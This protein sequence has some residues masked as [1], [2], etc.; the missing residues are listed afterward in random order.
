MELVSFSVSNYRSITSAYKLPIRSPTVLIGPNNE[1]K[2]NILRA[3]VTSA[4]LGNLRWGATAER[5]HYVDHSG[6]RHL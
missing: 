5:P 1:G 4:I 2:S 3:L 6:A